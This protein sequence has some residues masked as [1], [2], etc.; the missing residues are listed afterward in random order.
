M[1]DKYLIVVLGPTASGKTALGIELA[2]YYGTEVISA[3]SRQ[4]YKGL[5]IG[6]AQPT[7]EER[8]MVRHN[9]VD[10]VD[11]D[12]KYTVADYEVDSLKVINSLF[13]KVDIVIMV[14]G[15]GLYIRSICCGLDKIPNVTDDVDKEVDLMYSSSG[16]LR[17]VDELKK[18][19]KCCHKYIDLKNRNRVI[20]ALKVIKS[21]GHPIY[22]F[23]NKVVNERNF[24][25]IY[26]GLN[27]DKEILIDRINTR[28]DR[29]I[30]DG[31]IGEAIK[32]KKYRGCS[33]LQT[34]GYREVYEELDNGNG[35]DSGI[36]AD[37]I[38]LKTRQYAKRQMTWFRKNK[39]IMWFNDVLSSDIIGSINSVICFK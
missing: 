38:K 39:D 37:K 21:T 6:T 24:N 15:T 36:I 29:M 17:C 26:I 1:S 9:L 3:D 32:F 13:K 10:F 11:L 33:S 20:R 5:Y 28:V 31:L 12:R 16:L 18:L 7:Y 25:T 4:I 19:D 35:I 34:I 30:N 23:F 27:L 22:T 14:G 2:K 8:S